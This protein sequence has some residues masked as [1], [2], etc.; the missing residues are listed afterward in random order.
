MKDGTHAICT[1]PDAPAVEVRVRLGV[2]R[3]AMLLAMLEAMAPRGK[4]LRIQ[5]VRTLAVLALF[6]VA[7]VI[8][9]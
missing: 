7:T 8:R 6:T 3:A 5:V 2:K 9:R 1:T 4:T